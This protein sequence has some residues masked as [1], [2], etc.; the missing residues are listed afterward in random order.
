[1]P[2]IFTIAPM[3]TMGMMSMVSGV[4]ALQKILSGES[5]IKEQL[6][7]LLMCG[8]MLVSMILFPLFQKFYTKRK[9]IQK[10]KQRRKKY[11]N[12]ID[13]KRE[14]IKKEINY[15]KSV[16]IEN[17]L[18]IENVRDII[19]NKS[20]TLWERKIEHKD[21]LELRLGIGTRK[22]DIEIIQRNILQWMKIV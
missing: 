6:S 11:K 1:M 5:T 7:S 13:G 9:K 3:L 12:Y 2:L 21:F 15:Q 20:R 18:P 8:C 10:E 19:L 17:N 22:P 4:T 14:E 16:L